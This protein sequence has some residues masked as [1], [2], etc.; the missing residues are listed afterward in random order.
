M[1]EYRLGSILLEGGI[2]DEAGLERCLA[3]QALTGSSRPIGRILVEQ[4]LLDEATLTRLLEL[5]KTRLTSQAALIPADDLASTSLLTAAK[6]NGASEIVVSEGRPVR[7]RIG[8]SWQRLTD[9]TLSGPEVWDFVRETM[10]F[11]VL[12]QLAEN[13]FVSR[14]WELDGIGAGAATAFRQFDGVAGRLTFGRTTVESL[15]DLGIP[16]AVGEAIDSGK[17][18]VLCVGERGIG[19]SELLA[20]LTKHA[21]QDPSQ[22]VVVVG[23]EPVV[24]QE[25]GALVVQRQFGIDPETRADVLRSVV[26]EDPD[27]MVIADV[28][29]PETFELALR[30]AEGG[31]L[32]IAYLDAKNVVQALMRIFNFYPSYELPRIRVALAAVLR[33]VLVRHLLPNAE[34]TGTVSATEL[35]V[36]QDPVREVLRSGSVEDINLLLRA[37]GGACG[38]PLDRSM[39]DLLGSGLVRMDDVFA[40]AEEKAWLLERTR[41]LGVATDAAKLT[42]KN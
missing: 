32:V 12:E 16:E 14:P 28:G 7:V 40:R 20:S 17:G 39:L 5:Q 34:H 10:G 23:D 38:H 29:S 15:S 25:D 33:S 31:R 37:E 1:D 19:R 35:L 42:E 22:Y 30:A 24:C 6:A 9:E 13:H 21:A 41:N 11:D 3:I 2:V 26:R 36:V 27:V 4:G 18:L 8:S